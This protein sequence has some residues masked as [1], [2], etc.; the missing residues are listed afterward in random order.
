MDGFMEEATPPVAQGAVLWDDSAYLVAAADSLVFS[1]GGEEWRRLTTFDSHVRGTTL[2]GALTAL[3]VLGVHPSFGDGA[4]PVIPLAG[5]PHVAVLREQLRRIRE[6][7]PFAFAGGAETFTRILCTDRWPRIYTT[8][9]LDVLPKTPVRVIQAS[10]LSHHPAEWLRVAELARFTDLRVLVMFGSPLGRWPLPIDLGGFRSLRAL[11]LAASQ[12]RS[13]PQ[14]IAWVRS[15]EAIELANNP[16]GIDELRV[17]E[18]LPALRYVG[19][20]GTEVSASEAASFV[21]RLA[22]GCEVFV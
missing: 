22:D 20:R 11:D 15:L 14:S 17:L 19:L 4:L 10:D 12:L 3:A 9:V 1:L 7:A 13:L 6:V 18:R 16:I 21:S 8:A 5:A 2:R